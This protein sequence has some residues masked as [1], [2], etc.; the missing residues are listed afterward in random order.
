MMDLRSLQTNFKQA[1][2]GEPGAALVDLVR[3]GG[4]LSPAQSLAVYHHNMRGALVDA[5]RAVYPVCAR[6]L[7]AVRFDG[8]A[9]GYVRLSPSEHSDLNKY[10]KKFPDL[11]RRYCDEQDADDPNARRLACLPELAALEWRYHTAYYAADDPV[12]DFAAFARV[13]ER[14]RARIVLTVSCALAPMFSNYPLHRI[15]QSREPAKCHPRYRE[16][17]CIYRR[18]LRSRVVRLS[19]KNYHLLQALIS[20]QPLGQL[21]RR[22]GDMHLQLPCLIEKGWVVS[23]HL[24]SDNDGLSR[25]K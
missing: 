18:R 23:F 13:K 1:M 14:D 7:G 21:V 5:L 25:V 22:F 8:I 17:L 6:L 4:S 15:W 11:L 2:F 3:P 9:A 24:R 19:R 20:K 12:F 10:G 16:Y